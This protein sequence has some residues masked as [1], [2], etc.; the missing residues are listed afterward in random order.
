MEISVKFSSEAKAKAEKLWDILTD[1]DSWPLW[2]G[3]HFVK[4]AEP[5]RIKEG[6]T[7]TAELGGLKWALK[8]TKA[9]KPHKIVWDAKYIGLKAVHG[10]EFN[11]TN[12]RT[13]VTTYETMT[14]WMVFLTYPITKK[15]L[16]NVD[17][18][19]LDDLIVRAENI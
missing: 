2:Q 17:E 12:G 1:V 13:T 19:W 10:W 11:E 5:G 16:S 9:E 14:G 18:K 6:S 8:V 7:F 4:T 15:R 3:T